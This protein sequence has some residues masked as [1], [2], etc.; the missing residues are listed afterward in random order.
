MDFKGTLLFYE[1]KWSESDSRS[2]VSTSLWPHGLYSPWNSP[3]QNTGVDSPS[4]PP[5]DLPNPGIEHRS[6]T[7]KADSLPAEP[8]GRPNWSA[9]PLLNAYSG[10]RELWAFILWSS[11]PRHFWHHGR[12]F[13]PQA[14]WG[15]GWFRDESSTLYL[16]CT[17]FL[18][19]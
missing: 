9:N 15:R 6:P 4:F 10:L 8:P 2:V 14:V 5:G 3:G 19:W 1:L 16:L 17:I 12:Q 18:M 11:H 7:L 13:F